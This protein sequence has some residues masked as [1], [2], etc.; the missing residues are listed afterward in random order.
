M[1]GSTGTAVGLDPLF[2]AV[3]RVIILFAFFAGA[4]VFVMIGVTVLDVGLRFFRS[5]IVGAYDIVRMAGAVAVSCAL[6]Y[7]TAVKGHIA[8][9]FFY[10]KFGRRGRMILDSFFRIVALCLFGFLVYRNFLY[11][12][13]LMASGQV[14]PTLKVPVFWIPFVIGVNFALVCAIT[15]YHLLHPGKEMIKP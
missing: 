8:I 11:G 1:T 3:R 15:V 14:M 9:E 7:V 5:G 6:P 10:Q 2:S 13:I 4:A 12:L